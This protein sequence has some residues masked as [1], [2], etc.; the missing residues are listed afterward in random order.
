VAVKDSGIW[1]IENKSLTASSTSVPTISQQDWK[2]R[3]E[4]PSGP[5]SLLRSIPST[6]SLTF[7]LLG[8]SQRLTRSTNCGMV[9]KRV[10]S[11]CISKSR[12]EEKI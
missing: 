4:K 6:A 2:K 8:R 9:G 1:W 5:E 7:S 10:G 11:G 3:D 12:S